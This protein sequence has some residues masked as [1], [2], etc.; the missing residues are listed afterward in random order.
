MGCKV[1]ELTAY[2]TPR[3]AAQA[4]DQQCWDFACT[5]LATSA[6]V[7]IIATSHGGQAADRM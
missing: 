5:L 1:K 3:V 6:R 4:L 7:L 2:L